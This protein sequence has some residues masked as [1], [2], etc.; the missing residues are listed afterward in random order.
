MQDGKIA[1]H[2]A[3]EAGHTEVVEMLVGASGADIEARCVGTTTLV[4]RAGR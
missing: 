3:A 4:R 2:L 1:L